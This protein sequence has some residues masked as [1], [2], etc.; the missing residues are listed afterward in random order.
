MYG[1]VVHLVEPSGC[2]PEGWG[3][4]AEERGTRRAGRIPLEYGELDNV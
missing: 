1:P 3:S 2:T 4:G